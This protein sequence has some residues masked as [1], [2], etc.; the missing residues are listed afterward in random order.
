MD[1]GLTTVVVLLLPLVVVVWVAWALGQWLKSI[2]RTVPNA[3]TAPATKDAGVG[4][5]LLLLILGLVFLGPLLGAGRINSDFMEVESQFPN[6]KAVDS[7]ATLKLA[8]WLLFIPVAG[9]SVYAGYGL[10]KRRDR[11]VV[12]RAQIFLWII[13]PLQTLVVGGLLPI[14]I[15]GEVTADP[16]FIGSFIGSFVASVIGASLWTAY[17]FRSERVKATYAALRTT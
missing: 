16:Q 5:W 17:L 6:V 7:W 15:L 1:S 3:G 11:S 8:T 13:G 2:A 12:R 10:L 14:A 4:G 9:L